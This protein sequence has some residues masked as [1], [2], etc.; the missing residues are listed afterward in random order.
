M[1]NMRDGITPSL[2]YFIF[3]YIDAIANLEFQADNPNDRSYTSTNL[4]T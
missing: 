2:I 4:G 1:I 3:L